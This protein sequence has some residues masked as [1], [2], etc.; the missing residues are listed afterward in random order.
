MKVS[1]VTASW[2]RYQQA[3]YG[4][5][6]LINLPNPPDEIVF[7]DD[8][9]YDDTRNV[10]L[11]LK[12][13]AESRNIEFQYVYLDYPEARIS[14]YPHNVG[15]RLA[16]NEIVIFTESECL[17]VTDTV[18]Q[19]KDR[20]EENPDGVYV[21]T[22]L[23]TMGPSIWRQLAQTEFTNPREVLNHPYAQMTGSN[24]HNKV[25]P[26]SD[27]AI[28]GQENC[29]T[30]CFF[31]TLKKHFMDVRGYDE[32]FVGFSYDDFDLIHRLQIYFSHKGLNI[33]GHCNDIILIHQW[34]EKN[35]PYNIYQV[36]DANGHK[37]EL[38]IKTGQYV[39]NRENNNW[40]LIA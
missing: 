37:M 3:K 17:H 5:T 12:T 39:V 25:A 40:G 27:W 33:G 19:L 24:F 38:H 8:G 35:Y 30:G 13:L 32:E 18:K 14:C 23:W 6:S 15:L 21:A 20:I 29:F 9:S 2:N 10:A 31:G 26:D 11:H 28:S 7:V 4:I 1:V 34:H 36:G 22:Q 16:K